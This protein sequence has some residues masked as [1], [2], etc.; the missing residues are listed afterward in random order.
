LTGDLVSRARLRRPSP[1]RSR[2]VTHS[3]GVALLAYASFSRSQS[4]HL[5]CLADIFLLEDAGTTPYARDARTLFASPATLSHPSPLVSRSSLLALCVSPAPRSTSPHRPREPCALW[6]LRS[7][8]A[9]VAILASA[10]AWTSSPL[11][12]RL[13]PRRARLYLTGLSEPALRDLRPF[14]PAFRPRARPDKRAFTLGRPCRLRTHLLSA[15][16]VFS[17]RL[18]SSRCFWL[19]CSGLSRLL[20]CLWFTASHILISSPISLPRI[21]YS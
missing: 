20:I 9:L 11:A 16:R 12:L 10:G 8:L 2:C 4:F 19:R 21:A 3:F 17:S 15:L 1:G 6:P 14:C 13:R 5:V 18:V 7:V